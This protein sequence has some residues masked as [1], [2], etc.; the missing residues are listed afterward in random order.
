MYPTTHAAMPPTPD[1]MTLVLAYVQYYTPNFL[2]GRCLAATHLRALTAWFGAPRPTLRS[3]RAHPLLAAHLA[4][5]HAARLLA[6]EAGVWRCTLETLPWLEADWSA[7]AAHLQRALTDEAAWGAALATLGLQEALAIDYLAYVAQQLARQQAQQA[8]ATGLAT[9]L[10]ATTAA[11]WRMALPSRLR[12][13]LRFHLLQMGTWPPAEA[14][15]QGTPYSIARAA[16]QGYSLTR[17][18]AALTQAT[19]QPLSTPQ[20][21]Q[22]VAWYQRHDACRIRPVYLLS[23]KEPARLDEVLRQQRWRAHVGKRLGPRHAIVSPQL[24]PLW[25]RWLRAQGIPL[26]APEPERQPD[27]T[28]LAADAWLALTVLAGLGKLIPLPFTLPMAA[29]SR[30]EQQ[31]TPAQQA[32][33]AP[34]AQQI[35]SGVQA[36]IRGRDAYFVPEHPID[37]ALLTAV[38]AAVAQE[39]ELLLAYQALGETTPRQRRVEPHRLEET[40]WGLYLHGYCYLAEANRVFRLDRV[41]AWQWADND[42]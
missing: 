21:A 8:P 18:E 41:H 20:Q 6:I 30:L 16:Q 15:W 12:P 22:L 3:A 29:L 37:P 34:K 27:E 31:L 39:R 35:I 40:A 14:A 11:A 36:A 17:M 19:G 23:V 5:G 2:P 32:D 38:R 25:Q 9:W 33:L 42:E 7:Q 10:P 1:S 24:I 26:D 28:S 4:L 13:S